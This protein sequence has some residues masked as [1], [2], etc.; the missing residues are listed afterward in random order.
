MRKSYIRGHMECIDSHFE[1]RF[2][3]DRCPYRLNLKSP[4]AELHYRMCKLKADPG[5]YCSWLNN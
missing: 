4:R 2:Q 5:M 3:L 1:L